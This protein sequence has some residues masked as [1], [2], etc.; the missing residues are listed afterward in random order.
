[1][2]CLINFKPHLSLRLK[3]D[4]N[5]DTYRFQNHLIFLNPVDFLPN[6]RNEIY[7]TGYLSLDQKHVCAT[8]EQRQMPYLISFSSGPSFVHNTCFKIFKISIQLFCNKTSV[9]YYS[10][11]LIFS[12]VYFLVLY[13]LVSAQTYFLPIISFMCLLST[14]Y[15][16]LKFTG[17]PFSLSLSKLHDFEYVNK[18]FLNHS[19]WPHTM[20]H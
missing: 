11:I 19:K 18:S 5:L 14:L 1:M 2:S 7:H 4:A 8:P 17:S 12:I 6:H 3:I 10:V 13:R 9:S 20:P 15:S 16:Q